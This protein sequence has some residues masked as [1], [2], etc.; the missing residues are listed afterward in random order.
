MPRDVWPPA[1]AGMSFKDGTWVPEREVEDAGHLEERSVVQHR[2]PELYD[3]GALP[4]ER[5]HDPPVTEDQ[6]IRHLVWPGAV[7]RICSRWDC[8]CRPPLE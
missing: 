6:R 7:A 8:R 1:R 5:S 4:V 3:Q 2:R